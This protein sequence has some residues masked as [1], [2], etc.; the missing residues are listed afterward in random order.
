MRIFYRLLGGPD[1]GCQWGGGPDVSLAPADVSTTCASNAD[2]SAA[3]VSAAPSDS[4]AS[5]GPAPPVRP[6]RLA[7]PPRPTTSTNPNR[8][9]T[10]HALHATPPSRCAPPHCGRR[11]QRDGAPSAW[12]GRHV[13]SRSR[14]SSVDGGSDLR[15][16]PHLRPLPHEGEGSMVGERRAP[17]PVGQR[18]RLG[19]KAHGAF[20]V[21]EARDSSDGWHEPDAPPYERK[22]TLRAAS[23]LRAGSRC[24]ASWPNLHSPR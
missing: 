2:E 4:P 12:P 7:Q 24:R 3:E 20:P 9:A 17:E 14:S 18:R 23:L 22:R 15:S 1:A 10:R 8:S 6:A 21:V 16:I 13:A 5:T 11:V 19:R